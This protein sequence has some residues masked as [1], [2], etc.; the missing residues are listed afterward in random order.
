MRE[1]DPLGL[2]SV[3]KRIYVKSIIKQLGK[4]S[5]YLKIPVYIKL[6][7]VQLILKFFMGF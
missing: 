1:G 6:S 4:V 2:E 7:D 5:V 3:A